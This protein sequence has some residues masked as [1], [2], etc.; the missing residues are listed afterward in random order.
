MTGHFDDHH[1]FLARRMLDRIDGITTTVDQVTAAIDEQIAPFRDHVERLD[2]ITGIGV[3]S[4]HELI[5]E[6]GVDMTRFPT[7]GHLVFWAKFAHIDKQSAGKNKGR[8]TGTGNPWIAGTLGEVVA[9]LSRT[10]TFLGERYRHLARRR[11]KKRAIVALGNSLLTIIWHLLTDPDARYH[12]L[13]AD[14]HQSRITTH[15]RRRTLIRELEHLTGQ[16]VT[17]QPQPHQAA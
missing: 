5:A 13:G 1:A 4:A 12:D 3:R 8:S 11:G 9:G 15:R 14:Y 10:D 6:I 7:P 17:L 2:E 16:Q